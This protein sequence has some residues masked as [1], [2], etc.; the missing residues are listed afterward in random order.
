M[1]RK[2]PDG[3]PLLLNVAVNMVPLEGAQS[4]GW[5]MVGMTAIDMFNDLVR[6][7]LIVPAAVE[8]PWLSDSFRLC[9][10]S[11]DACF[12]KPPI[13][14]GGAGTGAENAKLGIRPKGNS[15]RNKRSKRRLGRRQGSKKGILINYI[16]IPGEYYMLL[17]G[18]V[19]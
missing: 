9:L 7:G 19:I 14:T 2:E 10:C 11:N 17:L 3:Q 8:P 13:Q 15:K 5:G 6:R 16:S 1:I 18:L 4:G 12:R